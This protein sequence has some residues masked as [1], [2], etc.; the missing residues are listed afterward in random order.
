MRV[1]RVQRVVFEKVTHDKV[2]ERTQ[3]DSARRRLDQA[4]A[5]L[6]L[7]CTFFVV[8]I[9]CFAGAVDKSPELVEQHL[10]RRHSEEETG[11]HTIHEGRCLENKTTIVSGEE[12]HDA[13]AA[14][15]AVHA[16]PTKAVG[17]LSA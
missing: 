7:R 17:I 6:V 16:Y 15:Y 3:G 14:R 12:T 5:Q 4:F 10:A 2:G 1:H 9:K 11:R 13:F 8:L